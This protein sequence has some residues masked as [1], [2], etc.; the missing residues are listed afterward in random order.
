[1]ND[2]RSLDFRA[3]ED[4]CIESGSLRGFFVKPEVRCNLSLR[5]HVPVSSRAQASVFGM[6]MQYINYSVFMVED[7]CS[8]GA[9]YNEN[10]DL[11]FEL[12]TE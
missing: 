1:M 7:R 5:S 3:L 2:S 6:S 10:G 12:A 9:D 4:R 8:C 11:L